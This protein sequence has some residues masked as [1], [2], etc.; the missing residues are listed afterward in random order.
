MSNPLLVRCTISKRIDKLSDTDL[1][2]PW[3][4]ACCECDATLANRAEALRHHRLTEHEDVLVTETDRDVEL[5]E[6]S[7]AV[8][9]R[10]TVIG[11][12]CVLCESGPVN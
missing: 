2:A 1:P 11:E 6:L 7:E 10:R 5:R 3:P 9:Q 12:D 8:I 4:A